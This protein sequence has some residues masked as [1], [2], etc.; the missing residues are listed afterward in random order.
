M[1]DFNFNLFR[2]ILF[3]KLLIMQ[4]SDVMQNIKFKKNIVEY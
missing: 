3:V 1:N 2:K 4:K